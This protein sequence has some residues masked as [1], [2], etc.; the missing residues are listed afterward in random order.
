VDDEKKMTV[1]LKGALEEDGHSVDT[2]Y[3]GEEALSRMESGRPYDL[4]ITDLRMSP[5]DGL[6]LLRRVKAAPPGAEVVLMTAYADAK[7]AVEAMKSGA[8][9]YIVKPFQLDEIKLMVSKV[10]ERRALM[11]ENISLREELEEAHGFSAIVGGSDAMKLVFD[12]AS[13]VA[14]TEATVLITGESGTGKDLLARA[15]HTHSARGDRPFVKVNC[16]AVP[17]TLLES[18]LFGHEKGAFTGAHRVKPGIFETADGGSIF[19]DEIGELPGGTQVKLLQ[20][21]QDRTFIRLGGNKATTVDVRV[22]AATNRD[23]A[24]AMKEGRFRE[25]LYYRLNVF[26]IHVPA[27]RDRRE[28]LPLLIETILKRHGHAPNKIG[29]AALSLLSDYHFPGNVRELE[30]LLERAL[31]LAGKGQVGVEHFPAV[32]E[33][34]GEPAGAEGPGADGAAERDRAHGDDRTAMSLS[35]LEREMII[36]ALKRAS[37]NKSRA[38]K[39]LGITRRALYS[40]METHGIPISWREG[41]EGES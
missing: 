22:I 31:I 25:D 37:G 12:M 21:L 32:P 11:E 30:N 35:K 34:G 10:M 7:T 13:K 8:Y 1:I 27:L 19:L 24:A 20:V 14:A 29:P 3:S 9:D 5:M 23:I 38:A 2:A 18:E 16:G 33:G 36:K 40:K 4:V 41:E 15:I 26:P 28:D 6:E 17:E 39:L